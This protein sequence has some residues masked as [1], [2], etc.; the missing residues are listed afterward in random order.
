[1][2]LDLKMLIAAALLAL[3]QTIPYLGAVVWFG[4]LRVAAGNRHE[5][6]PL[7]KWA[8]RSE[9]A[10]RNMLAT[11]V[12]FAVLVLVAHQTGLAN[13]ETA[14]GAVVF[15][16]ARL[17]YAIIYIAGIPYLRT[18]AFI[19]SLGGLFDIARVLFAGWNEAAA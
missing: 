9:R 8:H 2:A 19:V 1:M 15:F 5:L 7:P 10:Q 13:A 18:V 12:P 16:W 11:F 3:A 6:P 17:A 14:S 4:G